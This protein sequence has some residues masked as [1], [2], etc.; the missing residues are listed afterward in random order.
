MS[1]L[2]LKCVFW[3]SVLRSHFSFAPA[4]AV[5]GPHRPARAR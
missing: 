5:Y 3:L 2:S 4:N 1:L